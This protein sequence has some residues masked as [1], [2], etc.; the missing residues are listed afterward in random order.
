M[1]L[2]PFE[3]QALIEARVTEIVAALDESPAANAAI[4]AIALLILSAYAAQS[5]TI[6]A[7][8]DSKKL[9]IADWFRDSA[10]AWALA[11]TLV[12]PSKFQWMDGL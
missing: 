6:E 3:R 11:Q 7:Q 5:T 10:T 12:I 1:Y 4:E 8:S 9:T 2:T